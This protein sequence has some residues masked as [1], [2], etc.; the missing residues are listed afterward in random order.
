MKKCTISVECLSMEYTMTKDHD[1]AKCVIHKF[2]YILAFKIP[3]CNIA[4]D[5]MQ[6][7]LCNIAFPFWILYITILIFNNAYSTYCMT[8]PIQILLLYYHA[9][10]MNLLS[11]YTIHNQ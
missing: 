4:S 1:N 5:K 6:N 8:C 2:Y 7:A 11:A 10:F 3:Y 9:L